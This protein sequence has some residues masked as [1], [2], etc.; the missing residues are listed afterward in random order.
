MS[1]LDPEQL[2]NE[3]HDGVIQEISALLLQ[4]E[5][6]QRILKKDPEAAQTELD[7]IKKQIRK[8]LRNLRGILTTLR[9]SQG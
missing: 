8:T 5:T 9:N 2:A 7:R 6:Y 1:S 4:L 3:L